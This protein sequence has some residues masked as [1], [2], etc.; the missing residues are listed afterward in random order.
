[1][2]RRLVFSA[3]LAALACTSR[4]TT[5]GPVIPSPRET[6]RAEDARPG[7]GGLLYQP[8][9][10]SGYRI[11]RRDSTTVEIPGGGVQTQV[12]GRTA[13][14][15]V[16]LRDSAGG[17]RIRYVLDSVIASAG[18][19]APQAAFDSLA[20][21]QWVATIAP[22]GELTDFAIIRD[23]THPA[24]VSDSGP[25]SAPPALTAQLGVE[26]ARLLPVLPP[27]GATAGA[28]WTDTLETPVRSDGFDTME[29]TIVQYSA[30]AFEARA[31]VRVLKIESESR[32]ESSGQGTQYG[33]E[34]Q[35]TGSGTRSMVHYLRA[36]GRILEA[37]GS[38]SSRVTVTVPAV[39]QSVPIRQQ[40]TF[41][42]TSLP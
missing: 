25:A 8:N 37:S 21:T 2:K 34:V 6:P 11:E 23:S 42:I 14:V 40:G 32:F 17:Y 38:D 36:D 39:G 3:M 24:S 13:Y 18:S 30:P 29:R 16:S 33:Q 7:P 9:E 10:G 28:V 1:M 41:R 4:G 35:M 20:R 5:E 27:G 15:G 19:A 12:S 22:N 31:G 26:V